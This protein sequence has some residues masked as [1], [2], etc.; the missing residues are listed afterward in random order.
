M[1][2]E[3]S[4]LAAHPLT[5]SSQTSVTGEMTSFNAYGLTIVGIIRGVVINRWRSAKKYRNRSCRGRRA[6]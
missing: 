5:V 2:V 1:S 4:D 3:S 6:A